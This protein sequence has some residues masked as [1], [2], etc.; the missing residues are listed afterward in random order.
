MPVK[1]VE[2]V[3]VLNGHMEKI[4]ERVK[5]SQPVDPVV[6]Y[7]NE[8]TLYNMWYDLRRYNKLGKAR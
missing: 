4:M 2:I 1:N 7:Q 5:V 8:I 3:Q 6:E